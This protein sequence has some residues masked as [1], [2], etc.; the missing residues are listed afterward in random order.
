MQL[1]VDGGLTDGLS[2]MYIGGWHPDTANGVGSSSWGR[3]DQ[4]REN[5]PGSDVCWD[6]DGSVEP[7]GLVEMDDEERE[8]CAITTL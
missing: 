7:L 2:D 5:Q 1:G 4:N 6:R 8:V 3:N